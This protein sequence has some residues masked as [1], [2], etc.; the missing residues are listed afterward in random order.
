LAAGDYEFKIASADW[1]SVDFGGASAAD[2]DVVQDVAEQLAAKGANL[3]FTAAIDATYLFSLDASDKENPVLTVYNEE[4]F[5]GTQVYLRGD[6]NAWGTD[7]ELVY[8]GGSIYRAEI[9][10]SA[11]N[12]G[13]KVASSD[14]S[15]VDYGSGEADGVVTLGVE[16]L[17]AVKGGNLS[18]DVDSDDTYTFTFDMSDRNAPVLTVHKTEMFGE[19]TVYIRGGMNGWGE[20]DALS[21]QGSSL[22]SVDIALSAGDNEFK[23]ATGDWSTVDFGAIAGEETVVEGEMKTLASK[24]A[25][26]H[27]DVPADGT[28]RFSVMGP[29]ASSQ[30]LTVTKVN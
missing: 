12:K 25:N 8:M 28:Y 9:A 18:I 10:L 7:N 5:V 30:T 21:Y 16:K 29:D 27:L 22:Y 20:V 1:S 11:G 26:M 3:K 17:L 19:N 4:P 2:A 23:I 14:W 6:M 13:F 15:T 24:G